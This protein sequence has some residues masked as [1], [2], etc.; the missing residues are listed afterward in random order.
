MNDKRHINRYLRRKSKREQMRAY[1]HSVYADPKRVF[2]TGSIVAGY[3]KTSKR[4]KW[5]SSTQ[6]F[7]ANLFVNA[8]KES[9]DLLSGRWHPKGFQEFN[10]VER[11]KPRHIKSVKISEKCV[12]A[13]LC[14][15]CLIPIIQPSL[16]YNNGACL[17]GKGTDFSLHRLTEDLRW[18]YRHYG[19]S[20]GIFIFDFHSYFDS[21]PHR[22]VEEMMRAA[23]DNNDICRVY[24]QCVDA[25]DSGEIIGKGLGLGSQ[26]SQITAI[27]YPNKMIDHWVKDALGIHCFGRY[28]DDGYLICNSID[29]LEEIKVQFTRRASILGI[30]MNDKKCRIIEFGKTFTFLKVRFSVTESGEVVKKPNKKSV[31]KEHVKLRKLKCLMTDGKKPFAEIHQEFHSW[32]C[33]Q[34][35]GCSFFVMVNMIAYFDELFKDNGGYVPPIKG[36][37]RQKKRYHQLR[38]AKKLAAKKL[39]N[40]ERTSRSRHQR[41]QLSHRAECT[42]LKF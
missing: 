15:E 3:R 14:N 26:V 12:Q 13:A 42:N 4:S 24:N 30:E 25:F 21:I 20:G 29:R 38:Y 27:S 10:I 11:G 16:I 40:L 9:Q 17:P 19:M 31:A 8:S 37:K 1:L 34:N 7:G 28:N 32:L 33:S 5:K 22:E 36:K 18:H 2:S 6:A 35:K 41:C 39:V 23:I